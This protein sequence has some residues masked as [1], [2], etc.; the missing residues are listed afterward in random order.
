M[1][2][3]AISALVG[4]LAMLAATTMPGS[5][6]TLSGL[7]LSDMNPAAAAF[8]KLSGDQDVAFLRLNLATKQT[9]QVSFETF[10]YAG[11]KMSNGT[12]VG[13]GGFD[14]IVTVFDHTGR[15]IGFND[16][17]R[18]TNRRDSLNGGPGDSLLQLRLD[19]GKYTVAISQFANFPN[20]SVDGP[21]SET[22][23]NYSGRFGCS[24][25][26]FCDATGL[27]R[28]SDYAL[29]VKVAPIPVPPALPLMAAGIGALMTL[30]I[31]RR[32]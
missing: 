28:T 29:D 6:A 31:R 25:G 23:G 16:D 2:T 11:G 10:S 4:A 12:V 14:P 18:A 20:Y 13:R 8:G 15:M 19:P 1:K 5:A 30:R 24:N 27:N 21:Y 22:E 17:N 9:S 32:A 26:Q 7:S 3:Q